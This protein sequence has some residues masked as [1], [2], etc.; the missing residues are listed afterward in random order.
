MTGEK[1]TPGWQQPPVR[2]P[3]RKPQCLHLSLLGAVFSISLH[4]V[5]HEYVCTCGKV[6]VVTSGDDGKRLEPRW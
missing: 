3:A 5:G 6:W 1:R 2:P 4:P